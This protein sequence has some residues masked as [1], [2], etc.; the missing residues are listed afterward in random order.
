MEEG[1]AAVRR[2][3][4]SG[5]FLQAIG[6]SRQVIQALENN[7]AERDNSSQ[8]RSH[9]YLTMFNGYDK[10]W[11]A[12][13]DE[14]EKLYLLQNA[15]DALQEYLSLSTHDKQKKFD[16]ALNPFAIKILDHAHHLLSNGDYT[17]SFR[18]FQFILLCD[19]KS[20]DLMPDLIRGVIKNVF[21][22]MS[23]CIQELRV[24]RSEETNTYLE[25]FRN[26]LLE[27]FTFFEK[28][29]QGATFKWLDICFTDAMEL[30]SSDDNEDE[31]EERKEPKPKEKQL[32]PIP[33]EELEMQSG[34]Y[35]QGVPDR[36]RKRDEVGLQSAS[37]K[38][39]VEDQKIDR[40]QSIEKIDEK[41]KKAHTLLE[42]GE[43]E[44]A[45]YEYIKADENFVFEDYLNHENIGDIYY[46]MATCYEELGQL[47]EA[48]DFY[49]RSIAVYE[50]SK[51]SYAKK[52]V[53]TTNEKLNELREMSADS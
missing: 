51:T 4:K 53:K 14:E 7:A 11:K 22:N 28:E 1:R 6:V 3:M 49:K 17:F 23:Y 35:W 41:L 48:S 13:G 20:L 43:F 31:V 42:E 24:S 2:L 30:D 16:D 25:L 26:I 8:S 15:I 34:A 50:R 21:H 47:R 18:N 36:K 45:L 5:E 40:I 37:K 19:L 38:A 27:H 29:M 12:N 46:N 33:L 52:A 32:L 44:E 9:F 10:L 39:R